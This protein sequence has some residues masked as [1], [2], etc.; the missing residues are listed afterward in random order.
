MSDPTNRPI[1][2]ADTSRGIESLPAGSP[3][4]VHRPVMLQEVRDLF[5]PVPAGFI[6]DATVGGA[7]HATALLD[8]HPQVRLIGLDQD[9]MAL[10]AARGRLAHHG[11]RAVLRHARFDALGAV[12]ANL[13]LT[14]L[15]GV[16]FDLGVSSPQLD[17]TERG[18]S[19]HGDAPLD[20]RMDQS[21]AQT[22]AD[23]VNN[24]SAD[25]L[26]RVLSD[27]GDERFHRVIARAIVAARPIE[28]TGHLVDV[29]LGSLPARARKGRHP[30]RR[31][32]QAIRIE[33]NDELAILGTAIDQAIDLLVPGGRCVVLAYHSGE[34]RI[35]KEC[36]R[37]AETGGCECPPRLPCGCG[38][39]A[40]V[41]LL[42]R[43]GR[44]PG[45]EELEHNPRSESAR[46]RAV[47]RI[48][49]G[50]SR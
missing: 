47:E 21:R 38:A 7:G 39:V 2:E 35:V 44:R 34:D 43:G 15:S 8:T 14:G 36:F 10:D 46:L 41:R 18:F 28:T 5:A 31:T 20:M 19:Y 3:P 9:T 12:V 27:L 26:A 23:V 49:P 30:A 48:E 4:F 25:R 37:I 17:R 16:L 33:V 45:A 42:H 24:Y 1:D 22:A 50:A 13:G 29:V 32:F 6:V 40:K 11:E